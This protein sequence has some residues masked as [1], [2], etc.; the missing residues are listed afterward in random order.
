MALSNSQYQAIMRIYNE[1]QYEDKHGQDVRRAEVYECVPQVKE[2]EDEI[3]SCAVDCARRLLDGDASARQEMRAQVER[4]R[5]HKI[6]LMREHGYEP[7]YMEMRYHCPDCQDT[8][9]AQ[10]KKCHC[11]LKEQTRLLYAQSNIEDVLGRENFSTFS[12][13]VYDGREIIPQLEMTV[14]DYMRKVYGW[15]R[16]YVENFPEKGGNLLFTGGTGVGKTFL[17]N[18]IAKELIDRG[19]SVI[20]LSANDLV[21]VFSGNKFRTD[22]EEQLRDMYQF[23][24]DC[25]LLIIDDLGT[26]LNNSFVSSQLFYCINERLVRGKG[27]IISTNLT[28]S[29]LRDSY[30]DRVSSRI[31]SGYS[32]IPLYGED[33]RRKEF[34]VRERGGKEI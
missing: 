19:Q 25:D 13:D 26:E 24:L 33:L 1:R 5:R 14:A 28:V 12:F 30:S 31:T 22:P 2:I 8:G 9:Y 34:C 4:L 27:T 17:T 6:E 11:F 16:E 32:V 20:Y 10:G 3:A 23:V 15:C 18:C 7:D 21:D 29:M